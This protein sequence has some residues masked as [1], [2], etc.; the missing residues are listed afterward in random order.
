[1]HAGVRTLI[2]DLNALYGREP[3]LHRGD[4]GG[5]GMRWVE[6]HDADHGLF[7]WL[8]VDPTD[9]ARPV[10]VVV[11]ATP[12][13]QYNYRLGVPMA[14][15]WEELLNSDAAEYGG[16]GVGNFG[17]VSTAPLDSHDHHQSVVLTLPPL[18]AVA[19]TPSE[20]QEIA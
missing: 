11:N 14:G 18:A 15:R 19:L 10:L 3:A 9:Q 2:A 5:K 16:S 7:A 8:R 1:M 13:P 12:T 6:A 17:G 20:A 4:A